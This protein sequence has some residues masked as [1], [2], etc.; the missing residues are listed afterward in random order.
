[1]LTERGLAA[2]MSARAVRKAP[3]LLWGAVAERYRALAE[4]LVSAALANAS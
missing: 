1:V 4:Q 3:E 2:D